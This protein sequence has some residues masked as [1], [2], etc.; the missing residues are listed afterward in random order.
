MIAPRSMAR[1][2]SRRSAGTSSCLRARVRV[3]TGPLVAQ[4]AARAGTSEVPVAP[5]VVL[6]AVTLLQQAGGDR[7]LC[8]S[9]EAGGG[10]PGERGGDGA[11]GG[12][13]APR[14][15]ARGGGG[16]PNGG[17][18]EGAWGVAGEDAPRHRQ[19]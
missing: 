19:P 15:R 16:G 6:E 10:P 2:K 1:R 11:P 18:E 7:A 14:G 3:Q 17:G 5:V 4:Q 13:G 8:G 9:V 12:G